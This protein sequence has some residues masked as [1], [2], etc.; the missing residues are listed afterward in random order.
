MQITW[1]SNFIAASSRRL[2]GPG[3]LLKPHALLYGDSSTSR[4]HARPP[5][6]VSVTC[7]HSPG[8]HSPARAWQ[9]QEQGT[10]QR[11]VESGLKT[12]AFFRPIDFPQAAQRA[13]VPTAASYS[14]PASETFI[15]PAPE[16]KNCLSPSGLPQ[17]CL[18]VL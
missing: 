2:P 16:R 12:K 4:G 3:Q 15:P 5:P 10:R 8:G 17:T 14:F 13:Q 18:G 1:A 6:G 11:D 7:S 9:A